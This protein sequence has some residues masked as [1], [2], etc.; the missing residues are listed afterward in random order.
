MTTAYDPE[1]LHRQL[2]RLRK[3]AGFTPARVAQADAV[4]QVLGGLDMPFELAHERFVSAIES[5]HDDDAS[6]LL[7]VFRLSPGTEEL[8][9]LRQRREHHG[10]IIGRKPEAV[11]DRDAKAVERLRVQLMTGWYPKSPMGMRMSEQHNGLLVHA[12][13]LVTVVRHGLRAGTYHNYRFVVLFDDL[14]VVRITTGADQVPVLQGTDFIL[15]RVSG[16]NGH[17]DEFW[18]KEPMKRGQTYDLRFLA[19]GDPNDD[20][21][22]TEESLAFH[23]PLRFA[24]FEVVFD[25]L[26]PTRAWK[27]SGLTMHQRPGSPSKDHLLELDRGRVKANFRDLYGGLFSGTAWEW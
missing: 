15:K 21:R 16:A 18:H 10:R 8:A 1:D 4:R 24:S 22:I 3:D 20:R 17:T 23:E 2:I 5:L 12:A 9:L 27:F 25:A 14:D 11:A 13:H 19:P 26:V 6:V 7:D